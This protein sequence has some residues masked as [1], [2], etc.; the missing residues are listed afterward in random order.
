MIQ[1]SARF[2]SAIHDANL[3]GQ[4]FWGDIPE[5]TPVNMSRV[6]KS[7]RQRFSGADMLPLAP[8]IP[9]EIIQKAI[10]S[11]GF[12]GEDNKTYQ[13]ETAGLRDTLTKGLEVESSEIL[14]A[15]TASSPLIHVIADQDV[16]YLYKRPY[17]FQALI[18]SEA[19]KGHTALWDVIPPYQFGSASFG[20]ET[21]SFYESDITPYYRQAQIKYLNAPGSVTKAGQL[22]GLAAVPGRDLLAIRID[23]AQDALRALR[24]RAM[25]GV[26]RNISQTINTFKP[27]SPLE[28]QGMYE[29]ITTN[30]T[31]PNWVNGTGVTTYAEIMSKLDETY[32]KLVIDGLQPNLALCDY[33]TFGVIRR[34]LTEY[35]R[36][37]PIQTFTQGISKISLVFPNEGGLPLVPHP[38]LP[39]ASGSGCIMLMDTRLIARRILWGDTYDELAKVDLS[40][41]FVINAAETLIDKSDRGN[42]NHLP[43]YSLFG[44]LF[45][46]N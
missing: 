33:N 18:P 46:L 21:Q 38:F 26:D 24:E 35:F 10:F 9:D 16:T 22:A 2:G 27:A 31:E 36:T 34:G 42:A 40:Q 28:Y 17:P 41:K 15:A 5:G 23:A 37:D 29:L 43:A 13:D 25:L 1:Q 45:N 6:V 8:P 20:T 39:M 4:A 7:A 30:T 3:M 11:Y 14:K 32:N 12:S 19:C 44:G